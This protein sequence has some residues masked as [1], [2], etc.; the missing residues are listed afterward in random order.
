M[1]PREVVG[2]SGDTRFMVILAVVM[3]GLL[4]GMTHIKKFLSEL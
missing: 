1:G 4:L 3:K 2:N